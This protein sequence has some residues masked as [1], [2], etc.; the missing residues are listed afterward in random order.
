[1]LK[2]ESARIVAFTAALL[3]LAGC[4]PNPDADLGE[5]TPPLY[6]IVSEDDRTEGWLLGTI[7]ALPDGTEWQT[8]AIDQVT[9]DADSL[10][11]EVASLQERAE[12][13]TIF[14]DLA[15]TPGQPPLASRV[16]VGHV[17]SLLD[18][19]NSSDYK[20]SDFDSVETWAVALMLAQVHSP[21]DPDNGVD[22]AL[23]RSFRSREIIEFEG[24]RKQL[25]IFDQLPAQDQRDLLEGVLSETSKVIEDPGRLRRAWLVND[26]E[27]LVEATETGIMADPELREALLVRRNRD[28]MVQLE[29]LLAQDNR[30]LVAVGAAHLVGP[31]GLVTQLTERGYTIRTLH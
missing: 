27:A 6:E 3:A 22:R 4:S 15:T 13:Q 29:E 1:M 26:V 14:V 8:D 28:W 21:G 23:I 16:S 30:P 17:E 19:V 2:P 9:S 11:V 24:A 7:H 10:V 25:E 31:E 5:P 12:I 18:L 20:S